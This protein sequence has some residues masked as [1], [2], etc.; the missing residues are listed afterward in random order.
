MNRKFPFQ[1]YKLILIFVV[2]CFSQKVNGQN[3]TNYGFGAVTATYTALSGATIATK[4]GTID[5]G[6]YNAIPI[7]FGFWY[8]GTQYTTISAGTNGFLILG[9]NIASTSNYQSTNTLSGANKQILAPLWDNLALVAENSVTYSTTGDEGSKVFTVQYYQVRWGTGTMNPVMSFQVKLYEATG[10][11]QFVYKQESGAT[12][13]PSA[14][15]GIGTTSGALRSVNTAGTS[16]GSTTVNTTSTKQVTGRTYT[17]TPA[18]ATAPSGLSFT[19]ITGSGLTINW[20]DNSNNETGFVIYKSEDGVNYTYV[21]KT[22][23]NVESYAFTG[24][25]PNTV[26]YFRVYPLRESLGTVLSG[27]GSTGESSASSVMISYPFNG[28]ALDASGNSNNGNVVGPTLTE[29]RFRSNNSAYSFDGINDYI[30]STTLYASPGPMEFSLNLWF[31]TNTTSGGKL[32]GF[33]SS[34]SSSSSNYDRHIYMNNTGQ[35]IFGVYTGA[36]ETIKSPASYNDNQW[37]NVVAI[38]S[39]TGMKLYVDGELRASNPNVTTAENYAGYWK[40]GFDNLDGWIEIPASRYFAGIIDDVNV[41]DRELNAAEIST[42]ASYQ[43]GY[44]YKKSIVLN[45]SNIMSGTQTNFPYLINIT[46]NDL[47]LNSLSC[48]I[49]GVNS[50][51]GKVLSPTGSDI[52]FTLANGTALSYDIEKYDPVNGTLLAW[53]K[54]PSASSSSNL[55]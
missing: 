33:G 41:Y 25:A 3:M 15:V 19:N 50:T 47:K 18:S 1:L 38:L 54:L 5:N 55:E 48:D 28:N 29:D 10:A 27:S 34:T 53:I 9:D 52:A 44:A 6:T 12:S 7:G 30:S 31:K 21:T 2:V 39:G 11:I 13:S 43:R 14:T 37:H 42:S 45:T 49:S 51:I 26:Y 20:N 16:A 36:V 23:A 24:M 35:L 46:D 22:A 32:I 8:M 40:V 4:T 17:F